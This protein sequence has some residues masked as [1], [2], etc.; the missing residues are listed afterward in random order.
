MRLIKNNVE[1]IADNPARIA[2]LKADGFKEL[3]PAEKQAEKATKDLS[4]MDTQELKDLAKKLDIEGYSG[5]KK[6]ELLEV[7]KDVV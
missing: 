2:K 3:G 7:L 5:L 4:K 1:R 6:A